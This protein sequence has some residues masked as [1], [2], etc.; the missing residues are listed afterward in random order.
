[1][2]PEKVTYYKFIMI[3]FVDYIH[4]KS[5]YH[6]EH[7]HPISCWKVQFSIQTFLEIIEI[8]VCRRGK[9]LYLGYLLKQLNVIIPFRSFFYFNRKDFSLIFSRKRIKEFVDHVKSVPIL[10]WLFEIQR[11]LYFSASTRWIPLQCS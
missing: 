11:V 8:G 3:C 1:M 2:I 4:T 6:N 7:W 9:K 10:R 5:V